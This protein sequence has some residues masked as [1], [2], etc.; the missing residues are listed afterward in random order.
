MN[1]QSTPKTPEGDKKKGDL[2]FIHKSFG[3]L[4]FLTVPFRLLARAAGP[5]PPALPSPALVRLGA[6]IAHPLLHLGMIVM[7]FSGVAM[8]YYSGKPL[9]FF[10]TTFDQVRNPP[11]PGTAKQIYFFHR[12]FGY[13]WKAL[14]ILHV[15]GVGYH[16]AARQAILARMNPFVF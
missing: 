2:M 4:V 1:A 9:P 13:Y 7:S 10:F 11:D 12:Q 14:P 8:A 16:L 6:A 5:V 3:T 15:A